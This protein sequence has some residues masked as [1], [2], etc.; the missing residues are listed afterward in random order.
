MSGNYADLATL[1]TRGF[2]QRKM[3]FGGHPNVAQCAADFVALLE[4]LLRQDGK[5]S[6]LLGVVDGKLIHDGR[7]LVGST[8]V[9]RRLTEFAARLDTG[10]YEGRKDFATLGQSF[11]VEHDMSVSR[12]SRTAASRPGDDEERSRDTPAGPPRPE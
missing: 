6:L 7:Y 2:S 8:V 5:S 11:H 4:Q 12:R 10:G 3:Y 1:L 9:G